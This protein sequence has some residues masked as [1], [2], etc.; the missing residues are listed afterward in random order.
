MPEQMPPTHHREGIQNELDK[1]KNWANLESVVVGE[2]P[3]VNETPYQ[4]R[5]RY[6]SIEIERVKSLE[7]SEMVG[8]LIP[9]VA[10]YVKAKYGDKYDIPGAEYR[11]YLWGIS[12]TNHTDSKIPRAL[13]SS[14]RRQLF[15]GNINNDEGKM[16]VAGLIYKPHG[17]HDQMFLVPQDADISNN[18]GQY[19]SIVLIEK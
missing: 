10:E 7:I 3:R 18:L 13:K 9:E 12:T 8:K 11:D 4:K 16:V 2:N 14:N 6:E 17:I 15:L 5:M 19:D 1:A